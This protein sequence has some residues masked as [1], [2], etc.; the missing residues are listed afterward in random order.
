MVRVFE[1][2]VIVLPLEIPTVLEP[3]YVVPLMVAV[4][5]L[6]AVELM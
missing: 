1:N 2:S 3:L 5:D 6:L 4:Y